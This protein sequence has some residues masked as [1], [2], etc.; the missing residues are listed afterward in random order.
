MSLQ[1]GIE[2]LFGVPKPRPVVRRVENA[3]RV[4]VNKKTMTPSPKMHSPPIL[5]RRWSS[6]VSSLASTLWTNCPDDDSEAYRFQ[7]SVSARSVC[8]N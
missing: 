6:S 3:A 2:A 1:I 8:D 4:R 7:W 5:T